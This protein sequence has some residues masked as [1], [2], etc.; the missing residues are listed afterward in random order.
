MVTSRRDFPSRDNNFVKV[1]LGI[2]AINFIA[3]VKPFYEHPVFVFVGPSEK[4]HSRFGYRPL[5]SEIDIAL[6]F[7]F[8][9]SSR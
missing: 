9:V 6:A 4:F 8:P 3:A 5:A 7:A 1:T 2:V